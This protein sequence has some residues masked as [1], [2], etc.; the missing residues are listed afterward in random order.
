ML[1]KS[2]Q[3]LDTTSLTEVIK[4]LNLVSKF[5]HFYNFIGVLAFISSK[6]FNS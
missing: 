5:P 4:K 6:I 1:S 2:S 3:S